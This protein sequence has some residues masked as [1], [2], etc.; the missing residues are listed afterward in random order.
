MGKY[1]KLILKSYCNNSVKAQARA[2]EKKLAGAPACAL[3]EL[4]MGL[5]W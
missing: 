5:Q 1:F 4:T 3:T 2:P